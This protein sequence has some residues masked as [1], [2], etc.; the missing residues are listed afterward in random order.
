MA[1]TTAT[2]M[3]SSSF[4]PPLPTTILD[5]LASRKERWIF[6]QVVDMSKTLGIA[7]PEVM[8]INK[9][10]GSRELWRKTDGL[11]DRQE[12]KITLRTRK[13]TLREIRSTIAHE[14]I[15]LAFPGVAHG[16]NFEKNYVASLLAGHLFFDCRRIVTKVTKPNKNKPELD[17]AIAKLLQRQKELETR[18]KRTATAIKKIQR[19]I[20]HLERK[21][22]RVLEMNKEV[23]NKEI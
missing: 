19:K 21:K 17:A 13:R 23:E 2:T 11:A 5:R 4:S 20:K 7:V 15:H 22:Q 10:A 1:T 14:L 3:V 16:D 6:Q 9:V 8:L 12:Y 18:T